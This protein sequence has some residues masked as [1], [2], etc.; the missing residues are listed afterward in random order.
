MGTVTLTI[1]KKNIA[2]AAGTS[3]LTAATQAG[4]KIPR[5][6]Y[7][8][9]L[10][11]Y[12]AC[13]LCIV[14]DEK[15]GRIMAS[16]VTPV[17]P[18]MN[19]LTRSEKVLRHRRN[20]VRLMMAEHPES[21]IVCSKGN[22][23]ELRAIAADLGVGTTGL[24]PMPNYKPLESANP[25]IVRDLT[26]CILCGRC[27]RADHELVSVGA[28][29]Y[30]GRGFAARPATLGYQPL[31]NSECTFCGTCVSMCPTA[32]LT[33]KTGNWVGTVAHE[34]DSVCGFCA[35][36]CALSLGMAG[37]QVVEVNPAPGGVNG[38]T[39]CIRGHFAHDY[40]L[41]EERLKKPMVRKEGEQLSETS[42]QEA[43]DAAA[44]GLSRIVKAYGPQSVAFLGSS[45]CTNEENYLFQK[46]ARTLVKTHN[47]DNGGSLAGRSALAALSAR[48]GG[49]GRVSRFAG[50]S[51]FDA[52][53]VVGEVCRKA[54]VLGYQLKRLARAGMPLVVADC[55]PSELS[56]FATH[57]L[58][59]S[60]HSE[61]AL[62]DAIAAQILARKGHDPSFIYRVT[63]G[64]ETYREGL[65]RTDL[66]AAAGVTG[67]SGED[68]VA[69]AALLSEKRIAI[70]LGEGVLVS[71]YG[72]GV[73]H[74]VL[75][76]SLL[77]GSL[78]HGG[79]GGIWPVGSENN[80]AGAW[81]MGAVPESLP[82]RASVGD[83]QS[84]ERWRR[85]W[86]ADISPDSGLSLVRMVE[87]AESG[88]LKAVYIMGE[89][90]LRSFAQP[91]RVKKALEKLEL[92]VVQD[93]L[94]TETVEIAHVVLPGAAFAEK[95]GSFTSM[96]GRIQGFTAA[97]QPPG[98]AKGDL[99]ILAALAEKMGAK[100]MKTGLADIRK[101][102]RRHL[103]LY[104]D[105]PEG[106][107]TGWLSE[108]SSRSLFDPE[109]KREL[110]PFTPVR[111]MEKEPEE[112]GYPYAAVIDS[113][114][115]HL[116][117]GTRTGC[118][119]RI[120]DYAKEGAIG[121]C[122]AD[123][124][125]LCLSPGDGVKV[126]SR[127]GEMIGVVRLDRKMPKGRVFIP[128]ACGGNDA[129]NLLELSSPCRS[130]SAAAGSCRVTLTK[131]AEKQEGKV[132]TA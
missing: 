50:L 38:A 99:A 84:R 81:D 39:L 83:T 35:V 65:G 100:E 15:T 61:M 27:I 112:A 118:S 5:L 97:A 69:A 8:E 132:P 58:C 96:E 7:H 9:E 129:M 72:H 13:R 110:I 41:S 17:A 63:E 109:A 29:D 122:P 76:L 104:A 68:I 23:C 126:A 12:G 120:S 75:N 44:S 47:V 21:C 95:S 55:L 60:P 79:E 46:I 98:E 1:D 131:I 78:G 54:P 66:A 62:V 57:L 37:G 53:F 80:Q 86:G 121:I 123:A 6:C 14:E 67:L 30:D 3:I 28:I 111:P 49:G 88:R 114:R 11:P 127:H 119:K 89:N 52:L 74:A 31:E 77:T 19:L 26:K 103:P 45:K 82:G 85:A 108:T 36:G 90:P 113:P 116:G 10:K 106:A 16:C 125:A 73:A 91:Q 87:E 93:I 56:R 94:A 117:S 130:P 42:W 115:S 4:I 105:L 92:V 70:V 128:K 64:F 51:H 71:P 34:S 59:L 101:E 107:G 43:M 33:P 22:R 24:H 124:A 25:F 2:C 32:A 40:L 102:I 48:T 20:V 18:D